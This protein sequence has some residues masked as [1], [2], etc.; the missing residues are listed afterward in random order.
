MAER[1]TDL[2]DANSRYREGFSR[3]FSQRFVME[4]KESE[5]KPV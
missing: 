5:L 4:S 1:T 2:A 3:S